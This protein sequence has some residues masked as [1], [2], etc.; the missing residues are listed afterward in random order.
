MA[1]F[2]CLYLVLGVVLKEKTGHPSQQF[3]KFWSQFNLLF[4]VQSLISTNP[5][6]KKVTELHRGIQKA[7][8]ATSS[9]VWNKGPTSTSKPK[10]ENPVAMTLAPLSCPSC[11]ILATS[12][13]GNLPILASN[14][15]TASETAC[16]S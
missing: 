16:I 1:R 14:P 12:I 3:F 2:V 15:L 5:D 10:S 6:T 8:C 13:L 4:C 7:C 11:P 9:G